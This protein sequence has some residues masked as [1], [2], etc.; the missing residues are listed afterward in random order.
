MKFVLKTKSLLAV[1]FSF[2]N[3]KILTA[4]NKSGVYKESFDVTF[5]KLPTMHI[6]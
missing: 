1:S 5:E 4:V 6:V 3:N 2:S